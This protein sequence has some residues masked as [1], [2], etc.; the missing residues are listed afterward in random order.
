M[1]FFYY[2]KTSSTQDL[3]KGYLQDKQQ[4]VA[5]FMAKQQTAG[6]GKQGR[7]FYSPADS[8]L[9]FSI[10]LP[11]FK[12]GTN[13]NL[14]TPALAVNTLLALKAYF[15]QADLKIKWVNDLYLN[16]QKVAGILTESLTKGLVIGLG[17]NINTNIF[18]GSLRDK[19]GRITEQQL[20]SEERINLVKKISQAIIA[21]TVDYENPMFLKKYRAFS[22]IINR[23]INLKLGKQLFQGRVLTIDDQAR[24][25]VAVAGRIKEFSSGEVNRIYIKEPVSW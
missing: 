15:P 23:K 16:G 12:L 3:A 6:Y 19:A 17:I 24:L 2:E 1:R 25:I 22:N 21:A 20:K 13:K 18:P 5:I 11:N 8:G 9:Y 4:S 7:K 14:L 10:A